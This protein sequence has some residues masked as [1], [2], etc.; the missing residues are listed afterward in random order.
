[1]VRKPDRIIALSPVDAESGRDSS[2]AGEALHAAEPSHAPRKCQAFGRVKVWMPYVDKVSPMP[3][4]P[5]PDQGSLGLT[6]SQQ[7]QYTEPDLTRDSILRARVS[8]G[9]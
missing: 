7:F 5:T 2:A 3:E 4:W 1:M 8:S 9:V 6:R